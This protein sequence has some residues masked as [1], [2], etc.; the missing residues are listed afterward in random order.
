MA[1]YRALGP[2]F[3]GRL[4][5]IQPGEEFKSDLPPGRNWEP[6]DD[7]ARAKVTEYRTTNAKTLAVSDRLDPAPRNM[8]AVDIPTDWRC[9]HWLKRRALAVKLGAPGTVKEE[10]ANSFIEAELE[11][12]AQKAKAA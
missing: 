5:L 8:A 2:L 6:V 1:R 3:L 7:E 12:R 9:G 10:D 4:G 11:R